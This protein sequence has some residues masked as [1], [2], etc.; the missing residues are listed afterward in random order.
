MRWHKI[1]VSAIYASTVSSLKI[2]RKP[3]NSDAVT[4]L[5]IQPIMAVMVMVYT[6]N[7]TLI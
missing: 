6:V 3:I 1:E 7:S 2:S 5:S 4:Y